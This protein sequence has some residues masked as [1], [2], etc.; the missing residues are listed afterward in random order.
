MPLNLTLKAPP[1]VPLEAE[2]I[3]P[4]RLEGLSDAEVGAQKVMHGNEE[5]ELGE[6]FTVA[7]KA[8]GEIRVEGDCGR[9]KLIGA[10]MSRGRL[11]IA[12]NAGLHLGSAMTGG[13]I[14]VEGEAGDWLG[15]EMSGGRIEVK[16]DAGHTVGAAYR[17]SRVGMRGG[18]ILVHGKAGNEIGNALRG[19]LIVVG[20]D[21][22][23]FTGVNMLSG[24]IVVLGA[25]GIRSGAGMKRGSIVSMHDAEV[26]PTFTYACLYQ[27]MFLRLY[28]QHLRAAGLPVADAQ[29][30]GRYHRWSG[31]SVEL[32]RGEILLLEGA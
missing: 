8:N 21:A 16:G 32:N 20:G 19:G 7:G 30:A 14:V 11:V 18:E 13:E 28:L 12:G 22:G 3:A 25:L 29:I 17:G 5:A 2:A 1:A 26:L 27:P 4:D 24:T 10:G 15:A 31:D 23:D 6:F 9:I